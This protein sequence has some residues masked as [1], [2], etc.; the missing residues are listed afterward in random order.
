MRTV[1]HA[2]P[3]F[4]EVPGTGR[5]GQLMSERGVIGLFTWVKSYVLKQGDAGA[6]C[7]L[8]RHFHL[9]PY[10]VIYEIDLSFQ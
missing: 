5:F 3:V 6:R 9:V 4:D 1:D 10:T 7:S 2:E 8:H